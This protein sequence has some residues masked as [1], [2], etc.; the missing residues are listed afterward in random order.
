MKE[1]SYH[2][3]HYDGATEKTVSRHS[4]DRNW[5]CL[6]DYAPDR[7]R[8]SSFGC[9]LPVSILPRTHYDPGSF[10][11]PIKLD[12]YTSPPLLPSDE[13]ACDHRYDAN[14][15]GS[16]RGPAKP[17]QPPA[18]DELAHQKRTWS[19]TFVINHSRS[20]R[21]PT[22][23]VAR[24]KLREPTAANPTHL[25]GFDERAVRIM[26]PL[27]RLRRAIIKRELQ[28]GFHQKY[29]SGSHAV[30]ASVWRERHRG[31][32]RGCGEGDRSDSPEGFSL[33][34]DTRDRLLRLLDRNAATLTQSRNEMG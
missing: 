21:A 26:P 16:G 25:Q 13:P 31:N 11:G 28:G 30:P 12:A 17:P 33:V 20:R 9:D 14:R 29:R 23:R 32:R 1:S 22:S 4:S 18:D 6:S 19:V 3:G 8:F 2:S 7:F 15:H 27:D 10:R 34:L 24:D 5:L